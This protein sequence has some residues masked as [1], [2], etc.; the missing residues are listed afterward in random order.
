MLH[1]VTAP[2][3]ADTCRWIARNLPFVDHVALMGLENTGFAIANDALLWI[4]PV[5]TVRRLPKQLITSLPQALMCRST[6][7]RNACF[8]ARFGLTLFNRYRIGKTALSKNAIGAMKRAVAVVSSRPAARVSAGALALSLRNNLSL[9]VTPFR[10]I[11]MNNQ[12]R[13][14]IAAA[15]VSSIFIARA[16]SRRPLKIAGRNGRPTRVGMQA[17]GTTEKSLYRA[18]Q[19]WG[20]THRHRTFCHPDANAV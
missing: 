9:A 12:N 20:R 19:G 11:K 10:R 4:D 3:I 7:F 6:I 14:L 17:R 1:A 5:I 15:V 13:L 8:P 16:P 2:I 18:M